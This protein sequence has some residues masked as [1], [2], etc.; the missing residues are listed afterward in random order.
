MTRASLREYAAMQRERYQE[1]HPSREAPALGRDRGRDRH[2][3]QGGHP[4]AAPR[5]AA[6]RRR[7]GPAAARARTAPRSPPRPRSSG[8]PAAGSAPIASS[9]SCPSSW[10]ASSG[11][12]NSRSPRRST[13]SCGRPAGPP[14]PACSRPPAPATRGAAPRSPGPGTVPPAP[15]PHSHLHRVDDARPGFL[16]GRSRRPLWHEH[17]GLLPLHPVRRR[18]R[19]GWIELEA[20]WGKGQARVGGAV[21]HVR[22]RL[23]DAP[24]S[25]WTATTAPSSSTRLSTGTVA[26]TASPS[27]AAAPGR[28]TTVPMSSRR[29]GPSS[30]SSSAMI[31]SPPGR[32]C[33]TRA[34][35]PPRPPARELL[36]AG[37]EAR[38]QVPHRRA[39]RTASTIAPRRP[40]SGSAPPA[41]WRPAKRA[42]LDALYQRLNPLQLRRDLERRAGPALDPRRPRPAARRGGYRDS[43]PLSQRRLLGAPRRWL[44]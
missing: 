5:A 26:A 8:R 21:H 25:A 7:P 14:S 3:P 23:P 20:V 12:T 24:A 1:R 44:R 22:T 15:D 30:A 19:H 17:P 41:S 33:P 4:A 32:L 29:T 11:A 2:P 10:T 42:E 13:S 6:A 16:R 28:R 9:P 37:R 38:D 34:R 39:R 43:H 36:P 35:L 18:H 40:I 31:A 27:P